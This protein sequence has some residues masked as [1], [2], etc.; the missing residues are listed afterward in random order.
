MNQSNIIHLSG[1]LLS[2]RLESKDDIH[3]AIRVLFAGRPALKDT[4]ERHPHDLNSNTLL[5]LEEHRAPRLPDPAHVRMH[6]RRVLAAQDLTDEEIQDAVEAQI[7]TLGEAFHRF[8]DMPTLHSALRLKN[9]L[10]FDYLL[11]PNLDPLDVCLETPI[12]RYLDGL[13]ISK[14]TQTALQAICDISDDPNV[15]WNALFL[16]FTSKKALPFQTLVIFGRF[17]FF[18]TL[19]CQLAAFTDFPSQA[20]REAV[21]FTLLRSSDQ[22]LLSQAHHNPADVLST[23]SAPDI[24][25]WM[26]L[27]LSSV[28]AIGEFLQTVERV[29]ANDETILAALWHL[30]HCLDSLGTVSTS[31]ENKQRYADLALGCGH[32]YLKV[33]D[34]LSNADTNVQTLLFACQKLQKFDLF[35]ESRY[36]DQAD[37]RTAVLQ[38]TAVVFASPD[39]QDL[40]KAH[41]PDHPSHRPSDQ[42]WDP[43]EA[44]RLHLKAHTAHVF[45]QAKA[46]APEIWFPAELNRVKAGD[47]GNWLT[48]VSLAKNE[49]RYQQV[50]TWLMERTRVDARICLDVEGVPAEKLIKSLLQMYP[51][52]LPVEGALLLFLK[53]VASRADHRLFGAL[54]FSLIRIMRAG[55]V[56]PKCL[57]EVLENIDTAGMSKGRQQLLEFILRRARDAEV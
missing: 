35:D 39:K 32:Y 23:S 28:I 2:R 26:S 12:Q 57:L 7:K 31:E 3:D 53:Q 51:E 17:G 6:E 29:P 48:L 5:R 14:R 24:R 4:L 54:G 49:E 11:S 56:L 46:L 40:V 1:T 44:S 36:R 8:G 20:V 50:V 27:N 16:L 10:V 15:I 47:L 34:A 21:Y 37:L 22:L 42:R 52:T 19:C 38:K 41:A 9:A 33:A 45:N 43:L 55:G 18:N 13:E 30:A 25:F